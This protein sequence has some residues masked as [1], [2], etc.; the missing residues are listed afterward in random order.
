MMIAEHAAANIPDHRRMTF[1]KDCERSLIAAVD[2]IR[3]QFC[4]GQASSI[5][6]KHG[7][8]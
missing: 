5:M 8:P 3:Q 7:P 1:D 2:T 4:I 6:Q